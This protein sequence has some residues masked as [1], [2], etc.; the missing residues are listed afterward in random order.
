MAHLVMDTIIG[1]Q[2][3]VTIRESEIERRGDEWHKLTVGKFSRSLY[4]KG[5]LEFAGIELLDYDTA[6]VEHNALRQCHIV[7]VRSKAWGMRQ[8]S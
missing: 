8:A 4:I 3:E 2:L 1:H 6:V 5:L 7:H